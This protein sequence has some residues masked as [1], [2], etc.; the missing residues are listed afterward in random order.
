MLK[1]SSSS[2]MTMALEN[3][4]SNNVAIA[5]R[6]YQLRDLVKITVLAALGSKP[7]ITASDESISD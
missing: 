4:S 5:L 1:A 7:V 3:S 2:K 6:L